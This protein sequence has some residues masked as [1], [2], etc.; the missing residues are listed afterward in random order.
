MPNIKTVQATNLKQHEL[1]PCVMCGRGVMHGNA[2]SFY[3]IGLTQYV[4]NLPAIKRQHGLETIIG[5]AAIAFA[6]SPGE[7]MAIAVDH[8]IVANVCIECS[9]RYAIGSFIEATNDAQ[10]KAD[11]T[12]SEEKSD[13]EEDGL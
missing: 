11:A 1:M 6:L 13:T 5:N 10:Q 3:Q 12:K 8:E 2:M 9:A 4:V 7:D